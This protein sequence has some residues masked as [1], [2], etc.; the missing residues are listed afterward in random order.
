MNISA[1]SHNLS[2]AVQDPELYGDCLTVP[3]A[4][5]YQ[6]FQ[7]TFS[8]LSGGMV[9][10]IGDVTARAF[11]C[12]VAVFAVIPSLALAGA[13]TIIKWGDLYRRFDQK[14]AKRSE[15]GTHIPF[16]IDQFSRLGDRNAAYLNTRIVAD[17]SGLPLYFKPHKGCEMFAF[18]KMETNRGPRYYREVVHLKTPGDIQ[19]LTNKR[20][21]GYSALASLFSAYEGLK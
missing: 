6:A 19:A 13:G 15:I 17:Q 12:T 7:C 16:V 11:S 8:P 3:F 14:V 5:C 9:Q 18:D 4:K 21:G 10:K 1:I 20:G 2:T